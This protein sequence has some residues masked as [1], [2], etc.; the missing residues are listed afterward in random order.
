[1]DFSAAVQDT[2]GIPADHA[3][4]VINDLM[5]PFVVYAYWDGG[6][7]IKFNETV[8]PDIEDPDAD[9]IVLWD[10]NGNHD[11]VSLDGATLSNIDGGIDNLLT[12]P[13]E[14]LSAAG[15]SGGENFPATSDTTYALV[16]DEDIYDDLGFTGPYQH[17]AMTWGSIPDARGNMWADYDS[18][19]HGTVLYHDTDGTELCNMPAFAVADVLGPFTVTGIG[20]TSFSN[21]QPATCDSAGSTGVMPS[22]VNHIMTYSFSHPLNLDP[23]YW[24]GAGGDTNITCAAT[25]FCTLTEVNAGM[26][27]GSWVEDNVMYNVTGL[28]S[29]FIGD[30]PYLTGGAAVLSTDRMSMQITIVNNDTSCY[31]FA[32]DDILNPEWVVWS[33]FN[34]GT[35]KD[36]NLQ[37]AP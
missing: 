6:L 26:A 32:T 34:V 16:Y 22:D 24:E 15:I 35:G 33:A 11:V 14:N 4:V 20:V 1:M 25:D 9:A 27:N 37:V 5:P 3:Q 36:L 21:G 10:V 30:Q 12:I 18:T 29:G 2:Q 19:A 13:A 8:A 31:T 7:T 23:A 28:G 17:G